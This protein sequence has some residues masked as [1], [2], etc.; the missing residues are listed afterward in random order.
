LRAG[1]KEV[2]GWTTADEREKEKDKGSRAKVLA[3]D[4]R[5]TGRHIWKIEHEMNGGDLRVTWITVVPR[6]SIKWS[7]SELPLYS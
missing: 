6:N 1:S 2:N 5:K 4:D 7:L 3:C